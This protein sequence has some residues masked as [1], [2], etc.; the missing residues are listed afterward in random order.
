MM[1][2]T[3]SLLMVYHLSLMPSELAYYSTPLEAQC[4]KLFVM[5][6]KRTRLIG[7]VCAWP[8]TKG[9]PCKYGLSVLTMQHDFKCTADF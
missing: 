2:T 1:L 7:I 8:I 5:L 6:H 3:E 4:S 9:K